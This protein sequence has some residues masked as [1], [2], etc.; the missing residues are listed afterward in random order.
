MFQTTNQNGLVFL[1]ENAKTRKPHDLHGKIPMVSGEHFPNKTNPL[2][3]RQTESSQGSEL[4]PKEK[5]GAMAWHGNSN[6]K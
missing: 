2:I 3:T 1:R 5:H 6:V 4:A